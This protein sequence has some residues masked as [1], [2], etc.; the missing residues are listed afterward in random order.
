YRDAVARYGNDKPDLRFG[1]ELKDVSGLAAG[2]AFAV[3]KAA[4]EAGG[5]VKGLCVEGGAERF[6]RKDI[7]KDLGQIAATHGA[8]GLAWAKV[9]PDGLSGSIAKFFEGEAGRALC[10]ATG[11]R[12]GDL[13]LFVAD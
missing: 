11:A 9:G 1:M 3:F 12:E 6:S 2:S 7:E 5:L 10:E 4:V 8:K 13:L